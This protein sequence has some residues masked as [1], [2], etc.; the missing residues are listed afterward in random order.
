M[1]RAYSPVTIVLIE[2]DHAFPG[3]GRNLA[4]EE[5][6]SDWLACIDGGI[7]PHPDWLLELVKVKERQPEAQVIYGRYEPIIHDYF[8]ECA[9]ITYLPSPGTLTPFIASCLLHRSAWKTVGGFREDLRSGEDRLFFRTVEGARVR[10]ANSEKAVV[11]WS[12]QPSISGTFRRFSAYSRYGM[13]AG[14]ASEWQVSVSRFYLF[15]IGMLLAGF[16]WRPLFLTPV[17][18]LWLRAELRIRRWYRQQPARRLWKELL[19]PKR[20]LMVIWI[21]TVIDL[22]MFQGMWHWLARREP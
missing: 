18:L 8:T 14:L 13:K 9:A 7:I 17:L 19:N 20:V 11:Y 12:L 4:I 21:S 10:T 15:M 5:A 2:T 3:K 6:S 1:V 22:A 16:L